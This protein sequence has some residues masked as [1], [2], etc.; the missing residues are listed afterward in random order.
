MSVGILRCVGVCTHWMRSRRSLNRSP[1]CLPVHIEGAGACVSKRPLEHVGHAVPGAEVGDGR[2]VGRKGLEN[3][4]AQG[5]LADD[6]VPDQVKEPVDVVVGALV[7]LFDVGSVAK[8]CA[9][10]GN[11]GVKVHLLA[12]TRWAMDRNRLGEP[13]VPRPHGSL[14]FRRGQDHKGA[15]GLNLFVQ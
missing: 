4:K 15:P 9:G 5:C 8:V 2:L 14:V 1:I 13:L 11:V 3:A 12:E 6:K 7:V 10:P